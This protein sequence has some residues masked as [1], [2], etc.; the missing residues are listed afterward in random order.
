MDE[1]LPMQMFEQSGAESDLL[2]Y[3]LRF[4]LNCDCDRASS[5]SVSNTQCEDMHVPEK[6]WLPVC[7]SIF[8]QR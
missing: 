5:F 8:I 4:M 2:S 3:V 6:G 1:H 7:F